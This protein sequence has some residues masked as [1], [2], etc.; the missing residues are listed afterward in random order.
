MLWYILYLKGYVD[1]DLVG[2]ID[3]SQSTTSYVF[4]IDGA[5]VS[6]ISPL[7][8]VNYYPI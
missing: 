1:L 7:Q 8:K 2:D 3:T 5:A 6:S 4:T